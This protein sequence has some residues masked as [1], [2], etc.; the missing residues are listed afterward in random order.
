MDSYKISKTES[1][2]R[3]L[4]PRSIAVIGATNKPGYGQRFLANIIN[5]SYQGKLFP[6][7]PK[8]DDILGYKCY[9][10]VSSI[11]E[12]VD[13]AVVIV[14]AEF[15]EQIVEECAACHTGACLIITAGF[16][17]FDKVNG[18]AIELRMKKIAESSGMRIIGP[19]T[20]GS[21]NI[22]LNLWINSIGDIDAGKISFGN[23]AIISQSGAAGFGPLLNVA[24]DRNIALKYIVTTGNEADLDLCDFIDYML[25]D[26]DIHSIGILI[27]GIKD[28][29]RFISLLSKAQRLGKKLILMKLGESAVGARAALS[30]TASMTGDMAVFNALVKQYGAIKAADYDEMVEYT[31]IT[32]EPF[33]LKGNTLCVISHSGGISGFLGDI[34]GKYGFHIPLFS[35]DTQKKIDQYLKGFG[36]P[37]NPLDLTT[38][39]SKPSLIEIMRIVKENEK[40]DGYVFATHNSAEYI[41]LLVEAISQL[42]KPYYLIWTGSL[43]S[44]GLEIARKNAIPLS[45]S[46]SKFAKMLQNAYLSDQKKPVSSNEQKVYSADL[47]KYPAG[48]LDEPASKAIAA[49]I[50]LSIPE[51][52]V[53]TDWDEFEQSNIELHGSYV[54]KIISNTIIHKSDVGGVILNLRTKQQIKDAYFNIMQNTK[55]KADQIHG[56]LLEKMCPEGLDIMLGVRV[57]PQFGPVLLA[58]LGGIYT[59][60]F[61]MVSIRIMPVSIKEIEDMLDEI[62]GLSKLL[63]GYRGSP[64]YDRKSLVEAISKISRFAK[65]NEKHLELIESN[66]IRVLPENSGTRLLDCVIK[67]K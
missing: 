34:L 6:V 54:M 4:N 49:S 35:E 65:E 48:Y 19:N 8:Y 63:A 50:G 17:E 26:D 60:L 29:A 53:I 9:P 46:I 42:D 12:P 1:I 66:P 57:D 56:V 25:D 16:S 14:K 2:S 40:V 5:N 3:F 58:G 28:G 21:A 61:K 20:I 44:D 23:A 62:P 24:V 38:Q 7:N 11:D 45:F 41:E 43:Y 36:S 51:S 13:L 47:S 30:H 64:S 33:K 39:M 32:R 55:S 31:K 52:V 22:Q 59:E 18:K 15:V 37:R 10:S 27:E 67:I